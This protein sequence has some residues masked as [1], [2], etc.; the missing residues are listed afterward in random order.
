MQHAKHILKLR[1]QLQYGNFVYSFYILYN[2]IVPY[3]DPLL[4]WN[5]LH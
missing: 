5:F 4:G 2:F 1:S 3:D